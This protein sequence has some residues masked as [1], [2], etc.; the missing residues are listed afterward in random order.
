MTDD[1]RLCDLCRLS[2]SDH[3]I[4]GMR[5]TL[6]SLCRRCCVLTNKGSIR[7]DAKLDA[8]LVHLEKDCLLQQIKKLEERLQ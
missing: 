3:R 1:N 4:K 8:R 2:Y 7:Y 5:T 6:V